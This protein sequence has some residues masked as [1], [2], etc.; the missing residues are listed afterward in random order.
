M[1]LKIFAAFTWGVLGW[2]MIVIL[3]GAYVRATGSGAGCGQHWPLCNGQVI[4]QAPDVKMT[5]EF[6]HRLLSGGALLLIGTMVIWGFR[7]T[8][9]E[10]PVRK[11]LIAA[12]I[13]IITEALLGAGLVL[14]ELVEENSSVARA[15]TVALHLANTFLLVGS[16]ALSAYW[17]SGGSA[18]QIKGQG[19][20]VWL[21][22]AGLLGMLLIGMSGAVTALGDTLFPVRSLAEGIV[23]DMDPNAHFLVRLRVYHPIIAVFIAGYSLYLVRILYNQNQGLARKLLVSLVV[24]GFVQ[25]SA[26]L[27]NLLLLAPISMQLVH[28]FTADLV[29]ITYILTTAAILAKPQPLSNVSENV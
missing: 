11:G 14:F 24:I 12:G 19:A 5:I 21:L 2:I 7:I 8:N 4:P 22:G 26:G 9:R 15:F 20:K 1:K 3:W 18:I 13:L 16:L 17:A 25:L 23:A 29:W 27:T 10:Q 6:T 28:L